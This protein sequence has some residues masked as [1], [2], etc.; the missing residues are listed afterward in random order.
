MVITLLSLLLN[1]SDRLQF[2]PSF[3]N[4]GGANN[5]SNKTKKTGAEQLLQ[6]WGVLGEMGFNFLR[7]TIFL[8]KLEFNKK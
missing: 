8:E 4:G 6:C 3:L 7:N 2:L 1:L 5:F